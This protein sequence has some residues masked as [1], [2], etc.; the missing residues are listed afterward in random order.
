MT[1]GGD[2]HTDMGLRTFPALPA[3]SG[4]TKAP[5]S[6]DVGR[7]PFAAPGTIPPFTAPPGSQG[8]RQRKPDL[9]LRV[10]RPFRKIF[11]ILDRD[12]SSLLAL[13]DHVECP[14]PFS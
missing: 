8:Q 6:P 1:T 12:V 4:E 5:G 2:V 3:V 9:T 10:P 7:V 13:T 14:L 11:R